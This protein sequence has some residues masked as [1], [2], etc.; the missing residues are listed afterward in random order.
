MNLIL[1]LYSQSIAYW[2][3]AVDRETSI[4]FILQL[5]AHTLVKLYAVANDLVATALRR[6][7]AAVNHAKLSKGLWQQAMN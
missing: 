5:A 3:G 4:T 6:K 2:Y 7:L 1:L